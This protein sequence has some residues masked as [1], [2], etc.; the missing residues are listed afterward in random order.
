[1]PAPCYVGA[2]FL[3]P[4]TT[5]CG[6]VRRGIA[7]N[8]QN[9]SPLRA[10]LRLIAAHDLPAIVGVVGILP[11]LRLKDHLVTGCNHL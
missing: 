8:N 6:D 3:S 9:L 11:A 5:L 4:A 1:M 2:A 7:N 10:L